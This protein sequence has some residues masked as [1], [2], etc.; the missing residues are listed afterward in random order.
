MSLRH[1]PAAR[2]APV[3]L[4]VLSMASV[5]LSDALSVPLIDSL[6][7]PGTAWLRA[8]LGALLLLA[9]VR[10]RIR[11]VTAQQ[12]RAIVPLGLASALLSLT[13]LASLQ[14]LPLGTAVAVE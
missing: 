8:S 3:S 6:G 9:V 5:Q 2:T 7:A 13:F 4:T 11:S 12:W 10:P 14:W 1:S